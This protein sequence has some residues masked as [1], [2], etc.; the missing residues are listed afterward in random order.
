MCLTYNIQ[1]GKM[2][3][4]PQESFHLTGRNGKSKHTPSVLLREVF[5]FS[6]SL[7]AITEADFGRQTSMKTADVTALSLASKG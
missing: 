5:P 1:E 7:L 2:V 4:A 3:T 6:F